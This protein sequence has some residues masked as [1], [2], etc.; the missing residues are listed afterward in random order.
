MVAM[1]PTEED[2]AIAFHN[3][4]T[5]QNIKHT[6]IANESNL[7]KRV[8]LFA[9]IKKKRMGVAK[10]FPDFLIFLPDK[11]TLAIEL[12]RVSRSVTS[13]EQKDWIDFLNTVPNVQA[14]ICKGY[15]EAIAFVER[16]L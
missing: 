9:A 14:E 11:G 15:Q 13:P 8:A 6:H 4:L 16:F 1:V 3:W 12:K 2:D 10:G 5:W 7:P